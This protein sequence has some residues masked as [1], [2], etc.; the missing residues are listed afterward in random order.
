MALSYGMIWLIAHGQGDA[1]LPWPVRG[2]QAE[3]KANPGG[4]PSG[5][6]GA[7]GEDGPQ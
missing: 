2:L 6:P 1:T 5:R 3:Q 7:A 4:D